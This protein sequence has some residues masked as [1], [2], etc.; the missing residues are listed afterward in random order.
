MTPREGTVAYGI[1]QTYLA[2]RPQFYRAPPGAGVPQ[3]TLWE[4]WRW[5]PTTR[6][7]GHEL[8]WKRGCRAEA[9]VS[10]AHGGRS[11]VLFS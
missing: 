5:W 3:H 10:P 11:L 7:V 6:N 8:T 2:M 9:L 1:S 4:T